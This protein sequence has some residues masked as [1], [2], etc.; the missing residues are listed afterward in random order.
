MKEKIKR[1]FASIAAILMAIGMI[2]AN[3]ISVMAEGEQTLT[4]STKEVNSGKGGNASITISNANK[5]ATYTV[6]KVFDATSDGSSDNISYKVMSSKSSNPL[7][8]GF[9]T[10]TAGNVIYGTKNTNGE[11]TKNQNKD[12]SEE[13]V[14]AIAAYVKNDKAIV[15]GSIEATSTEN[16]LKFTNLEY[17]YYYVTSSI[18]SAVSI[19][20]TNPNAVIADKSQVPTID[21]TI[22]AVDN[23]P[24]SG[25]ATARGSVSSTG[26]SAIAEIGSTVHFQSIIDVKAGAE[27]YVF[28][29]NMNNQ[30]L[31]LNN[32]SISVSY[33]AKSAS[34]WTDLTS[35][36]D[37]TL[38]TT[39]VTTGDDQYTFK[40]AFDKNTANARGALT[41]ENQIKITYSAVVTSADLNTTPA[42]NSATI[43][44][45]DNPTQTSTPSTT[46]TYNGK[47][48]ITKTF[49]DKNGNNVTTY[50]E[51]GFVLRKGVGTDN[52]PYLYYKETTNDNNATDISWV[53]DIKQATEKKTTTSNNVLVFAGLANEE[54]TVI[55][56]TV[57][58]GYNKAA[59]QNFIIY[60]AQD[61]TVGG[62]EFHPFSTDNL[63]HTL[64][65]ENTSGPVL[66]S[67]GGMGTKLF[68]IAGGALILVAAVLL[69]SRKKKENA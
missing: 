64:S 3:A 29:D 7:P 15:S 38:Y 40:I 49:T 43:S 23:N 33:K 63:V 47:I 46:T 25:T 35:G 28:R 9:V 10:D 42:N 27:N 37:Y 59:D 67:T 11:I 54:Y 41:A 52:D 62:K 56:K 14:K 36:T 50:P 13:Q 8:T 32:N 18:G 66:P 60:G 12:L 53:S 55:E 30:P 48:T 45:G 65:V 20:S 19:T 6:Y 21:K 34:G 44:Y 26:K 57:P 51:A 61:T 4:G 31:S 24:G 5:G 17:G 69:I 1:L 39:S 2:G 22:T 68:Y 58:A 16:N